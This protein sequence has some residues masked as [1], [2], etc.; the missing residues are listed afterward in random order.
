MSQPRTRL[1]PIVELRQ[2]RVG[3]IRYQNLSIDNPAA[4]AGL[5]REIVAEQIADAAEEHFVAVALNAK[6]RPLVFY[7]VSIGTLT[8]SLVHP[9]EVFRVAIMYNAHALIVA[10]NHPSGDPTPSREDREITRRLKQA[11]AIL[12]IEL[13]DHLVIGS[14]GR[15]VSL[16]ERGLLV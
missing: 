7:T 16:R 6:N 11:G 13:Y 2:H 12:G 8:A 3:S 9:R 10:H 14:D 5:C 15:Y 1:L 4:A